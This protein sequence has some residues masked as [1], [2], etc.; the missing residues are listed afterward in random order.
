M[1]NQSI[2][3]KRSFRA[4]LSTV[5]ALVLIVAVFAPNALADTNSE[6]DVNIIDDGVSYTVT[7][8][9]TEPIEILTQS[10]I[11]LT[12]DD[13]LDI[14]GF[15]EGEGGNIVITRLNSINVSYDNKIKTYDVYSS[16]IA[17]ALD[18]LDITV[19]EGDA[20][21]YDLDAQVQDGMVVDIKP[22][23]TVT[24][25]ADGQKNS[26]DVVDGTVATLLDKA[27]VVLGADDYT[28]PALDKKL[29]ADMSVKVY[30]VSFETVT[31]TEK[32]KF[33]TKYKKDKSLEAGEQKVVT[34]GENGS[35]DVTYEVK[36]VNGKESSKKEI[37]RVVTKEAVTKVVAVSPETGEVKGNGVQSKNGYSVG[38]TISG[39]YTHYCSCARCCG[40]SNGITAS[41]KRVYT[42]MPDP[43]YIACNWLPMGSVVNV[44]GVNYTVVD[45]GGG[46]LSRRGRIDIY[47][48]AG[49]KAALKGGTGR[50]TITIV[51]L[52][53]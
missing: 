32:I 25:S 11:T 37:E 44:K 43:H 53:W 15:N 47:T 18:E 48:P 51:R 13:K 14:S 16:N 23:F 6:Y 50:C 45:R 8:T 12:S 22:V 5:I 39:K 35:A 42:G 19:N 9:E 20:V 30:R 28:K 2:A 7:T 3:G 26:F 21:N 4:I 52:G 41:G 33:K 10:G 34:K 46:G 17:D 36:Y 27:G 1:T 24:L 40:K 31:K 29:K 49:H 38:Q